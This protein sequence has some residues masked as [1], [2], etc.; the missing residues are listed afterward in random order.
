LANPIGLAD[1]YV[2]D[3]T[4]GEAEVKVK[5][6]CDSAPPPVPV[7]VMVTVMPVVAGTT[8]GTTVHVD[9]IPQL[10][11]REKTDKDT[12]RPYNARMHEHCS[13]T[14]SKQQ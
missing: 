8:F 2:N 10:N 13:D 4:P 5:T 6:F 11:S 9:T 14:H 1:V 12:T 3:C 7:R